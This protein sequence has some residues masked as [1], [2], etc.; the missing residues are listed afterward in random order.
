MLGNLNGFRDKILLMEE[1]LTHHNGVA[2]PDPR[3]IGALRFISTF[4]L[5]RLV[6]SLEI[7][8]LLNFSQYGNLLGGTRL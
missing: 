6:G 2:A 7:Y 3:D 8:H 5:Q 1:I 4:M